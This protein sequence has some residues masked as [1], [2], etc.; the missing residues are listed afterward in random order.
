MM[1]STLPQRNRT[2]ATN[3]LVPSSTFIHH[4][5]GDIKKI[6][7]DNDPATIHTQTVNWGG[8][9]GTSPANTHW[10]VIP[11]VG[12]YQPGSSGCPLFDPN[13]PR[14][15]DQP[16]QRRGMSQRMEGIAPVADDEG[17]Y[18]NAFQVVAGDARTIG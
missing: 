15:G 12:I 16:R 8:V 9:F 18:G 17:R 7:M 11:D 14:T 4:P 6:S 5:A 3:T 2:A 13:K 10:R 1:E